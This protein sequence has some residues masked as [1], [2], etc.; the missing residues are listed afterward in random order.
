M[1]L[2]DLKS[3]IKEETQKVLSEAVDPGNWPLGYFEVRSTFE[4]SPGGGWRVT[5]RQGQILH[6]TKSKIDPSLQTITRWD[7]LKNEWV[8]VAPPISGYKDNGGMFPISKF[9]GSRNWTGTFALNTSPM[10][11]SA[12]LAKTKTMAAE[13]TLTAKDAIK[14][15][16]G[17]SPNQQVKITIVK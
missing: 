9:S 2:K 14:M 13:T 16:Q 8:V 1:K 17:L 3:I 4:I 5:F 11:G 10:A 6:I 12:A 7:A 15:L